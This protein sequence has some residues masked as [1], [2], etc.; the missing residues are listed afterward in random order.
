MNLSCYLFQSQQDSNSGRRSR[1]HGRSPLDLHHNPRLFNMFGNVGSSIKR[2]NLLKLRCLWMLLIIWWIT[3]TEYFFG[4]QLWI[5]HRNFIP[6]AMP[7]K[8][9]TIGFQGSHAID[10]I[11]W[12]F[13]NATMVKTPNGRKMHLEFFKSIDCWSEGWTD[14]TFEE[15]FLWTLL[16]WLDSHCDIFEFNLTYEEQTK[17][18]QINLDSVL[19]LTYLHVSVLVI[20]NILKINSPV[21]AVNLRFSDL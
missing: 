16:F 21:N 9:A 8:C 10:F 17:R 15:C 20:W 1:R 19:L 12:K 14:Q 4:R 6:T 2:A 11:D 7:S 13:A 5:I 3:S 18:V